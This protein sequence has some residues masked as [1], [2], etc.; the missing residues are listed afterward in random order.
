MVLAAQKDAAAASRNAGRM[1][2]DLPPPADQAPSRQHTALTATGHQPST[3]LS[4]REQVDT[5]E[6][7][8]CLGSQC[9]LGGLEA[10]S[11]RHR[12]CEQQHNDGGNDQLWSMLLKPLQQIRSSR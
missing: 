8:S 1:T 12:E 9:P 6:Y 11:A 5:A 10:S 2:D 3:L 7:A 4:Q